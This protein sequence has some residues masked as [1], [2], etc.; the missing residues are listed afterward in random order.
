MKPIIT[1]LVEDEPGALKALRGMLTEYCPQINIAGTAMSVEEALIETARIKPELIFLDIELQSSGDGFDFLKLAAQYKFGVIFTTAYPQH[2]IKAINTIQ[3]WA[4]LV[5]PFSIDSLL[6]A[7][8][9]AQQKMN[10]DLPAPVPEKISK[11]QGII[12]QDSRKGNIILKVQDIIYCKS[13]RATLEVFMKRNDKIEKYVIYNTL[14]DFEEQLPGTLFCRAHHSYLVNLSCIER[15][16][17]TKHTRTIYLNTGTEIPISIQKLEH[18][19]QK[20][21]A[22]LQ[23]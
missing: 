14:K 10:S 9:I 22:F 15:Y 4:Y 5:K 23:Q 7:V 17:S 18:F 3:P 20:M 19:E 1:L 21:A 16:E 8:F 2:A 12:I 6:K 11:N 13:D